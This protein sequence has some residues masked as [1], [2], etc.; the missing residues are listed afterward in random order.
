MN[1]CMPPVNRRSLC[2]G[3]SLSTGQPAAASK[4]SAPTA[5]QPSPKHEEASQLAWQPLDCDRAAVLRRPL[6]CIS[7]RRRR[8]DDLRGGSCPRSGAGPGSTETGRPALAPLTSDHGVDPLEGDAAP[9][10]AAALLATARAASATCSFAA[11]LSFAK[12]SSQKEMDIAKACSRS[13]N[14]AASCMPILR[15]RGLS[16]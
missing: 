4:S 5:I 8:R 11:S 12:Q 3:A 13:R 10:A 6:G 1:V 16:S 7:H 14:R 15:Q 9:L 2:C